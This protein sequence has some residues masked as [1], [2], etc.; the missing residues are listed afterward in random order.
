M[1]DEAGRR[2]DAIRSRSGPTWPLNPEAQSRTRG[3]R[4]CVDHEHA[5][6]ARADRPGTDWMMTEEPFIRPSDVVPWWRA[7][8]NERVMATAT[9][10]I[11]QYLYG[12]PGWDGPKTVEAIRDMVSRLS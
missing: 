4:T 8:E 6:A 9:L 3:K 7:Q 5:Q 12:N 11:S 1:R 2:P 10:I